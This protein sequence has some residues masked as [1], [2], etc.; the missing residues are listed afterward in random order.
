MFR[1][2]VFK[3]I[4]RCASQKEPKIAQTTTKEFVVDF[5]IISPPQQKAIA[6]LMRE[7]SPGF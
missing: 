6:A 3:C 4:S 1:S 5:A 7:K 2:R